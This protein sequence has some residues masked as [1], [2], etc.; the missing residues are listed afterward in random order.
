M[1]TFSIVFKKNVLGIRCRFNV[2]KGFQNTINYK[3]DAS[4]VDIAIN[5]HVE[6]T[7]IHRSALSCFNS[8]SV[9]KSLL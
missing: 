9:F 5:L 1:C 4:H 2:V 6:K 8:C 7:S 3:W